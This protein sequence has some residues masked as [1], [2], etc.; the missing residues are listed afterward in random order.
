ME[1]A[2]NFKANLKL[3]G[4]PCGWCK[5]PLAL[6]E[7]ASVCN[8]CEGAHHQRCWDGQQG[9]G[10][11]GCANAP[12]KQMTAPAPAPSVGAAPL[13]MA[14]PGLMYCNQCRAL[15]PIG[16]PMCANCQAFTSPDNM[17]HG[18]RMN[19]PG[20]V[21]SLVCGIIGLLICGIVFGPIA[22]AQSSQAKRAIAA[23]PTLGGGGMATA[24]LILGILDL[25]GWAIVLLLNLSARSSG[26]Y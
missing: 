19:A 12:L 1:A 11:P 6:G 24:G 22:I 10:T 18:P 2:R 9:C 25:V 26:G 20:A 15:L 3:E 7:D 14:P 16:A 4:K 21:A 17:Y 23:D 8:G 5:G 13:G